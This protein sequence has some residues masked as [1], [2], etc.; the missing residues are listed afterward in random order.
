LVGIV[1]VDEISDTNKFLASI[2]A[3]EKDDGDAESILFWDAANIW[4]IGLENEDVTT[5]RDWTNVNL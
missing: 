2:R 3:R 4:W 1:V 5:F